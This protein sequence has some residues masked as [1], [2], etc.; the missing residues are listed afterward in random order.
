[1]ND[2]IVLHD[3]DGSLYFKG[4]NHVTDVKYY[5]IQPFRFLIRDILKF[6]KIQ[7]NT[8]E[9]LIFFLSLFFKKDNIVII[10]TAPF[11]FRFLVYVSI[12]SL[13]N[14]VFLHTSWP[15]WSD[16]PPVSYHPFFY[17]VI[18]KLWVYYL[19][20]LSGIIAVTKATKI[21]VMSFLDKQCCKVPYDITQIYH[22]VDIEPIESN[23]F[24]KKWTGD[25]DITFVGRLETEKGIKDFL[26]L[27][28]LIK[29]KAS[30][31]YHVLGKGSCSEQLEKWNQENHHLYYGFVSDRRKL[32]DILEKTNV[33]ILPS[34][35]LPDW[36]EL[37]GLVIV[38][39]MSQGV[40]VL[41]T[42]HVGPTEI[43][44]DSKDSFYFD[45]QEFVEKSKIICEDV[46]INFSKYKLIGNNAVAKSQKFNMDKIGKEWKQFLKDNKV[47]II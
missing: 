23:T 31:T 21:S 4:L 32:K 42:D 16:S 40:I 14:S 35:R 37:F 41:T 2:V 27:S 39:A 38:E 25:V 45:E 47:D 26:L 5:N 8:F 44:T 46:L 15:F 19:P 18:R 30:F 33:L 22:V 17:I 24:E 9:S 34:K 13:R 3:F 1:L 20:R 7:K 36:E 29:P 10:G 11:N 12:L 6:K 28:E 43:I